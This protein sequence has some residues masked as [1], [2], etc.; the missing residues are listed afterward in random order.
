MVPASFSAA[1]PCSSP[2]T[3]KHAI[4]GSTAPFMVMETVT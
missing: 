3:M 2:A 1:T 4:T